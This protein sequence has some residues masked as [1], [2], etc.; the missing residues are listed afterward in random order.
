MKTIFSILFF[1]LG[2]FSP[3]LFNKVLNNPNI[4]WLYFGL[5]SLVSY[6][7]Y[8]LK[9]KTK[10][11]LKYFLMRRYLNLRNSITKINQKMNYHPVDVEILPIQNKSIRLWKLLLR[12][13][14][15]QI[16]CSL[17]N[18]I[19]QIEKDN[20]LLI[21]S[22][23][24]QVDFQLTIMDVDNNK[25]CLYEI[26]VQSKFAESLIEIF[27]T[28][29]ERRMSIGQIEKRKSIHNDLDKLISQQE[30]ALKNKKTSN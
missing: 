23:I 14:D 27:D 25:S 7:T 4:L 26:P 22:P 18:R 20:M 30:N 5:F 2:L 15:S 11:R 6:G 16:S 1:V 19:R 29:N 9:F 10:S 28:E 8:R 24:N 12:D 3:L 17:G 13:L 21:L